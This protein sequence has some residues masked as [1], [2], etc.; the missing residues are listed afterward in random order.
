MTYQQAIKKLSELGFKLHFTTGKVTATKG[1]SR[2]TGNNV[3]EIINA[4]I[5]RV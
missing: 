3:K 4:I 2:Y 5:Y 1:V